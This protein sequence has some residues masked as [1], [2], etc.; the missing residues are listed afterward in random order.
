MVLW[1]TALLFHRLGIEYHTWLR[2][3]LLY[4]CFFFLNFYLRLYLKSMNNIILLMIWV[5]LW[6]V[7][8]S[9]YQYNWW[10]F[11]ATGSV[12]CIIIACFVS[13]SWSV[14]C[15]IAKIIYNKMADFEF[16]HTNEC[17]TLCSGVIYCRGLEL[18]FSNWFMTWKKGK[19]SL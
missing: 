7:R 2:N 8:D 5:W 17:N 18:R 12:S 1:N 6:Q 14:Y 13:I 10:V 11:R 16:H 19:F 9:H 3:S 4:P 15:V